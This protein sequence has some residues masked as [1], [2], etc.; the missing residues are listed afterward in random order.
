MT[1]VMVTVATVAGAV[2]IPVVGLKLIVVDKGVNGAKAVF[3]SK[4]PLITKGTGTDTAG[5]FAEMGVAYDS[6]NG[7]F[8]MPS[9][10]NWIV[11]S[12]SVGK[13][14]NK[15][16]PT[17]G[18][19]KVGVIKPGA[20]VKV[21]GK[22]LGDTPIDISA[23]PTGEVYV[24]HSVLNGEE[25]NRHCTRFGTCSHKL[26]AGGTGYKL[27]CKGDSTGDPTCAGAPPP[28]CCATPDLGG[29]CGFLPSALTCVAAGGTPGAANSSCDS[30][31]GTCIP[32]ASTGGCC[33][34]IPSGVGD[35]CLAGPAFIG[36]ETCPG[37][38]AG[39]ALCSPNGSCL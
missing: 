29:V 24:A 6:T 3:V 27:V 12:A 23:P 16:A 2:D 5:I 26:I 22:S 35:I 33:E 37:T 11:N 20:L 15:T 19:V 17:G 7:V 8:E 25:Y 4:D 34:G 10:S 14:V 18:A 9:G 13:Y 31:T 36:P 21:V 28:V 38:Y 1:L 39:S 30:V 32:V